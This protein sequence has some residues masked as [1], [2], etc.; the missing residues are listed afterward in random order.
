MPKARLDQLLIEKGLATDL[1]EAHALLLA[2]RLRVHPPVSPL[3]AGTLL[4]DQSEIS[5]I[6]TSKFVSRGGDK[7]ES[8]LDFW[9]I[10][11]KNHVCL[12]VGS[13]TGG[14]TDC[15]LQRGADLVYAVDVGRGQADPKIRH[16]PQVRLK[17]ETHF[18]QWEPVW[19][20]KSPSLAVVDVSFISLKKVLP[21]LKDILD[22]NSEILALIKP[23][24]EVDASD[25]VKGIVRDIAAREKALSEVA[26]EAKKLGFSVEGRFP[27]PVHG[28]KGNQEEWVKLIV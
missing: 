8:A 9:G 7:L 13:S 22:K 3:K 6:Q 18:L 15:L 11:V 25:L 2:G 23:Q 20:G 27:C 24:F 12:D 4:N 14:F 10:S 16:H 19:E 5:I 21:R 17:E 28:A 26:D 1:K